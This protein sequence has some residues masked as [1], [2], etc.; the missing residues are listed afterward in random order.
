[1]LK[2]IIE[3]ISGRKVL[4]PWTRHLDILMHTFVDVLDRTSEVGSCSGTPVSPMPGYSD[5]DTPHLTRELCRF[6]VRRLPKRQMVL[7]LKE[8]F[9]YTHETD[10]SPHSESADV[11]DKA[12][13]SVSSRLLSSR[14]ERSEE[15]IAP[16][17]V[18]V[19][20]DVAPSKGSSE[21]SQEHSEP[22]KSSSE[23][24][25]GGDASFPED[26]DPVSASQ[27]VRQ[28]EELH[29]ALVALIRSWP[30]LYHR[31]LLYCPI[32]LPDLRRD[33]S[34]AGMSVSAA[35]LLDFLDAQGITFSTGGAA[36]GR[37]RR[38]KKRVYREC[39]RG[40]KTER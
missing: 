17:G 15:W 27:A 1:M 30:R 18:R 19:A 24:E 12:A 20:D 39:K 26:E 29:H 8:I 36:R 16:M 34:A 37:T 2:C 7:K 10:V 23:G 25:F 38:P 32:D 35:R 6:G 9:H 13:E 4:V 14:A 21:T 31:I 22:S 28:K 11:S 33:L 3:I 40:T 5:M